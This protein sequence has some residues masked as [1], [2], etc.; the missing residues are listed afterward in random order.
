MTNVRDEVI[1]W[2]EIQRQWV[3]EAGLPLFSGRQDGGK[4]K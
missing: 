3:R 4:R 1:A 2:L